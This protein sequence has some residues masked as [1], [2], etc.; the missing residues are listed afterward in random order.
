MDSGGTKRE[1]EWEVAGESSIRTHRNPR[2]G[3]GA[4]QAALLRSARVS[5][6]LR[7]D[8]QC[9]LFLAV[10]LP[11]KGFVGDEGDVGAKRNKVVIPK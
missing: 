9:A 6:F 2:A 4:L 1:L 10:H 3:L 5:S 8:T 11:G 7:D